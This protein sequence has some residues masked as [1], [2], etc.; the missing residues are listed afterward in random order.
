MSNLENSFSTFQTE[1]PPDVSENT[2]ENNNEDSY[3]K[4]EIVV[5][6]DMITHFYLASLTIV[7]LFVLFRTIQKSI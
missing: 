3:E 6:F 1:Q 2:K 5:H 4:E 7:G